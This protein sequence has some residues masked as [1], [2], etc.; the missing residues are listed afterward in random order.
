MLS[1]SRNRAELA[2]RQ[3]GIK[4]GKKEKKEKK[5]KKRT[6]QKSIVREYFSHTTRETS[7]ATRITYVR[8]REV[9]VPPPVVYAVDVPVCP[10]CAT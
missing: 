1:A 8:D 5:G 4:E 7:L 9:I 6:E 3:S 10:M 2:L